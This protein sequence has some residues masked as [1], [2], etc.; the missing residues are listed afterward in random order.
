[1]FA[2]FSKSV[3]NPAGIL[4]PAA[5]TLVP[6]TIDSP[7]HLHSPLHSPHL[8]S[9]FTGKSQREPL[10]STSDNPLLTAPTPR[11]PTPCINPKEFSVADRAL[12]GLSPPLS[13]LT[14]LQHTGCYIFSQSCQEHTCPRTFA[15]STWQL[16]HPSPSSMHWGL[17]FSIRVSSQALAPTPSH[18]PLAWPPANAYNLLLS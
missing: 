16:C 2:P 13:P 6:V 5:A 14:L 1:M 10:T 17:L 15:P 18:S 12:H 9:H 7:R 8:Y 4:T 11:R 3:Q